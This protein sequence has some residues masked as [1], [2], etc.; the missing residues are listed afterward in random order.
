MELMGVLKRTKINFE[1]ALK[2]FNVLLPDKIRQPFIDGLNKCRDAGKGIKDTCE[3]G[4]TFT[5]CIQE[6]MDVFVFP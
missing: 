3:F 5:K 4:Y 1:A 6:S 2:Q